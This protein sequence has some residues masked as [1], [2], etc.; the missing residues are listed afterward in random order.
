MQNVDFR[1]Y[2]NFKNDNTGRIEIAEPAAF[3]GAN[4]T[5][6]QER[7]K[8]GRDITFGSKDVEL[9][10]MDGLFDPTPTPL[11]LPDG[12]VV[13]FLTH[14]LPFLFH[15]YRVYGFESRIEFIVNV[16]GT[17]FTVGLLL[18]QMAET[19][20]VSYLRCAVVQQLERAKIKR[21]S[22]TKIDVFSITDLNLNPI[23]PVSTKRILLKAKPLA[24]ISEWSSESNIYKIGIGWY[25]AFFKN[26][27][28]SGIQD[29]L[30]SVSSNLTY[31]SGDWQG[32][33]KDGAFQFNLTE[34]EVLKL[35][36]A[37]QTLTNLT[38]NL[39]IEA[40]ISWWG[41]SIEPTG[42]DLRF[43]YIIMNSVPAQ[44]QENFDARN[45]EIL[46]DIPFSTPVGTLSINQ[47]I[48]HQSQ[49]SLIS[50]TTLY[51]FF[52]V[53]FQN[54]ADN[55]IGNLQAF[56][57]QQFRMSTIS[58]GLSIDVTS[59]AV[60]S[61]INGVRYIDL[62]KQAPKAINGMNLV[63]PRW[64]VG[65]E[66]YDQYCFN[67]KLIRQFVN[68]PFYVTF[69]ELFEGIEEVAGNP[70]I[71]PTEVFAGVYQ[72]FYPNREIAAY[73]Q[74]PD[75]EFKYPQ[76]NPQYALKVLEY[77]YS[78][79]EKSNTSE[80]TLD[81]VH[82]EAQWKF[83]SDSVDNTKKIDVP[84]IRD[85]FSIEAARRQGIMTKPT[86]S[87]DTDD[88]LM[89]IDV[90]ALPPGS[91]G[92]LT[93]VLMMQVL[94]SGALQILNGS[95]EDSDVRFDWTLLGFN[96]YSY[97]YITAGVNQGA[98]TVIAMTNSVLTLQGS[99]VTFTGSGLITL[100]YPLD[101]V[102]YVNRTSQG[103]TQISNLASGS[104]FSNLNYTIRHN[105]K[106][107]EPYMATS[108]Q[109]NPQGII[110]NTFFKNNGDLI[111]QFG[112]GA[113]YKEN[114]NIS[115]SSLA[116][117]ILSP[118]FIERLRLAVSFEDAVLMFED[119]QRVYPD[120]TTGGFIRTPNSEGGMVRIY[121]TELD[122][123]WATGTL[124]IT[125]EVRADSVSNTLAINSL[126]NGFI[127]INKVG[128]DPIILANEWY[129]IAAGNLT[130]YDSNE[131]PLSNPT[132]ISLVLVNGISYNT[133]QDLATVLSLL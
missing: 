9:H 25:S 60:D 128:Y 120:G 63:A 2:L 3:D 56:A 78:N 69:K 41:G 118:R 37:T 105:L 30:S 24:Q 103:F 123:V 86:T 112:T 59:T 44:F 132:E 65:G 16:N 34:G 38:V 113:V 96:Y 97:V 61:V 18:M 29:T 21:Q 126:T 127:E 77:K 117:A 87:V 121:P 130:L 72:D 90:V 75:T 1:F 104:N 76:F 84:H 102:Q 73:H 108:C 89:I 119:M 115:V 95:G 23:V 85:P 14:G 100:Q 45:Y 36:Y 66:Y 10:F 53:L 32:R 58:S 124:A 54:D 7:G 35:V 12:T 68:E 52:T 19:D 94:D 93:A 116:P 26:I 11:Q 49:I 133:E 110:L 109:Y 4:F 131:I 114:E 129:R 48:I 83:P 42:L 46:F 50:G 55:T 33:D 47:T 99:A 70:Q 64:D 79:Y 101:N 43:C 74:A 39:N 57:A 40:D 5:L 6:A 106:Y 13:N 27:V 81:S 67:G 51:G 88:N 71:T 20:L 111:T 125:G 22:D 62:L 98:Y 82:T 80:N 8:W 28:T 15:Y 91:T 17:D 92:T 107:W 31:A 122:Y